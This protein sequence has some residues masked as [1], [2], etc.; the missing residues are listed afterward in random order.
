MG[1]VEGS[2]VGRPRATACM[3]HTSRNVEQA[4]R[5]RAAAPGNPTWAWAGDISTIGAPWPDRDVM[6]IAP[7]AGWCTTSRTSTASKA[8]PP[9]RPLH[10]RDVIPCPPILPVPVSPQAPHR[11][12]QRHH[13]FDRP[14]PPRASSSGTINIAS[15]ARRET[16]LPLDAGKAAVIV[17][18]DPPHTCPYHSDARAGECSPHLSLDVRRDGVQV[19]L[20][21]YPQGAPGTDTTWPT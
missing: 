21:I 2:A 3:G 15:R 4:R 7:I 20:S 8:M 1:E 10:H 13:L 16:H 12:H 6:D 19:P 17:R 14:L 11:T 9:R 18:A 5:G